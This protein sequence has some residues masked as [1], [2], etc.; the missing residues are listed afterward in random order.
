MK[1]CEDYHD[2]K[3]YLIKRKQI[4]GSCTDQQ[5]MLRATLRLNNVFVSCGIWRQ[6]NVGYSILYL[7]DYKCKVCGSP[8]LLLVVLVNLC[9]RGSSSSSRWFLESAAEGAKRMSFRD[10]VGKSDRFMSW[11]WTVFLMLRSTLLASMACTVLPSLHII[12]Q[13]NLYS[14]LVIWTRL[15]LQAP[16]ETRP[17]HHYLMLG[18]R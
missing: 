15:T 7:Y 17:L 8:E 16:N 6:L 5:A 14:F 10:C 1:F 18:L 3:S 11:L 2:S 4:T 13:S 12:D 9:I